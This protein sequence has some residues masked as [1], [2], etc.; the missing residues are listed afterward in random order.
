MRKKRG[1][2]YCGQVK[3]HS[4]RPIAGIYLER[5]DNEKGTCF[6]SYAWKKS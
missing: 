6:K 1:C 3:V 4:K 2:E 5:P